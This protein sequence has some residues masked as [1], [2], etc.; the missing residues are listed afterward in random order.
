MPVAGRPRETALVD[1]VPEAEPA[2]AGLLRS[3]GDLYGRVV[4]FDFELTR[5]DRF[6][7]HVWLAPEPRDRF[8]EQPDGT[9]TVATSMPF[10]GV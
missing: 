1:V 10:E 9:W 5:V 8:V 7:E 2:V 6:D 3:L 4:A